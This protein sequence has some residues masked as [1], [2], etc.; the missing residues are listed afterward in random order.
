[1]CYREGRIIRT[2]KQR[3]DVCKDEEELDEIINILETCLL[4][5]LEKKLSFK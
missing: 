1:M 3:I 5:C 4:Y 2:V